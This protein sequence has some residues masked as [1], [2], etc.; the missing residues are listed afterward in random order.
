MLAA[1]DHDNYCPAAQLRS[2]HQSLGPRVQLTIV[3]GA[4]HFFGGHEDELADVLE[5]MLHTIQ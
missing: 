1:G 2:L 5:G 3:K 4:D